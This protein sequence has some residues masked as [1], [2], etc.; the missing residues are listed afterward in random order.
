MKKLLLIAAA[1]LVC[2]GAFA[3]GKLSFDLNSDNLIYLTTD[4]NGFKPGDATKTADGFGGGPIALPGSSLYTG[5]GSTAAALG[6]TWV[7]SLMGGA[8]ANSMSLQTTAELADASS[9]NFGGLAGPQNLTFA[10]L[11][12]GTPAYFQVDVS[13][14]AGYTGQ[15]MLFQATPLSS[16]YGPIYQ[17]SSV[18]PVNSTWTPGTQE[19]TD[20]VANVGAG[21]GYF[22]GIAVATAVPE[23]GTFALAGL[24]LAALLVL[25]R[26][27]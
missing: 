21:S 7:V 18:G 12:A 10:S 9:S 13:N 2:V 6:G 8:A 24:G 27:S 14:G 22:G 3:Q 5:A 19:M 20:F 23:P 25:R 1:T 17:P 11:P 16:V 15:S 4:V 26:R